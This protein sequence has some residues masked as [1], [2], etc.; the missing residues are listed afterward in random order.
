M[1]T[2]FF[3]IT[4]FLLTGFCLIANSSE[5][6]GTVDTKSCREKIK[7]D[8]MSVKSATNTFTCEYIKNAEGQILSGYCVHIEYDKQGN[9]RASYTYTYTKK[10]QER[11][12]LLPDRFNSIDR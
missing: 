6:E 1:K 12:H 5:R 11:N 9:C 2:H 8:K 4:Y 10:E 7:I 3:A